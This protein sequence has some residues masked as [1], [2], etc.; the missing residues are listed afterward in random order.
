MYTESM[1]KDNGTAGVLRCVE[2]SEKHAEQGRDMSQEGVDGG[3]S[4][5][6]CPR[7]PRMP[8]YWN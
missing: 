2:T 6:S 1:E 5:G 7:N 8:I 3:R 4:E